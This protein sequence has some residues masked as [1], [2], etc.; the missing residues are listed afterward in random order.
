MNR[1]VSPGEI[2]I[3]I[4]MLF[5]CSCSAKLTPDATATKPQA[6]A[7]ILLPATAT[8]LSALQVTT[9]ASLDTDAP[10]SFPLSE[11]GPYFTGK[12]NTS[13]IDDERGKKEIV[14]TLLYP[15]LKQTG[16][17][18]K[19]IAQDAVAD[20]SGA[21]YPLILT[22]ANSGDY[23]FKSHLA[24]QGFVMAIVR[25]PDWS[26][27]WDFG[28]INYPRDFLF[29][30]NQIAINPPEG[31]ENVIDTDHV[32]VTGYSGDGSCSLALSGVRVDPEFYLS[33]CEQAPAMTLTLSE[34]YIEYTCGLAKE[35]DAFASFLGD[36]ITA[37]DD[38]LWQPVT[39]ER[40]RAVMP[41]AP[42]GAWLYGEQGLAAADRPMFIIAPTEDEYTP[43]L[44]ETKYI[45]EHI[46]APELYMVS[47]IGK[48]HM[49][50]DYAETKNQINHFATAFF[51]YYLQGRDDYAE[52]FSE[53][54]VAQFADLAWGMYGQDE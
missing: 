42:D 9:V 15:A 24:S 28:M 13:F 46:G 14:V 53:D 34:G 12:R 18:G 27:T 5:A 33:Y 10:D 37:S 48:T 19:I 51:G 3:V 26:N 8:H 36:E 39:D 32:G 44:I 22:G 41:M 6:T 2:G 25:P 54:F 45:F 31:F 30:L 38:G 40:I 49:M 17:D 29:V 43:Y 35:W 16:A 7:T 20:M 21:P 11:P 1:I 47:F 23:L 52:Y 50:V 4:F